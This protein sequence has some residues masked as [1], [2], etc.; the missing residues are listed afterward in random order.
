MSSDEPV[1]SEDPGS[2]G[3]TARV[4]LVTGNPGKLAEAKR[5]YPAIGSA[6]LDLPEIQSLDLDEVLRQKGRAAWRRLRRPLIVDETGL[7][8]SALGGFP[9]PLVKWMLEAIGAA[10]LAELAALRGDA[11]AVAACAL[12]Y[13]DGEREITARGEVDGVLVLPPRGPHGFGWDPVFQP[14]GSISTYGEMPPAEKDRA[15]HRGRAWR[16]LATALDEARVRI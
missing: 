14:L 2:P 15:S 7:A 9:G 13:T 4:V 11:R 16:A 12:F 8:L 10:G 5:L 3:D 6:P 1:T